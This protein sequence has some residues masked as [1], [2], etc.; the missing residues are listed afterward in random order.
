MS[1][2]N[3]RF[4]VGDIVKHTGEHLRSIGWYT[5]VPK[6]GIVRSTN[7][8]GWPRVQWCDEDNEIGTLIYPGC[9]M[10]AKNP[11]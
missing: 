10:L 8:D 9:I 1:V 2:P 7:K 5:D 4:N 6:N 11:G 3:K